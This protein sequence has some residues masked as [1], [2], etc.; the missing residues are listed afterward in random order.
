MDPRSELRDMVEK[1]KISFAGPS[2]LLSFQERSHRFTKVRLNPCS[3]LRVVV[4]RIGLLESSAP[5]ILLVKGSALTSADASAQPP[6]IFPA[7]ES[8][9]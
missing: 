3:R 7:A 5:F 2:R 4:Y 8:L 6:R 1:V 9:T